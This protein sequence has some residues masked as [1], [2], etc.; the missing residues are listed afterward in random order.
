M[1][2]INTDY[3][4]QVGAMRIIAHGQKFK[5]VNN[6]HHYN[7]YIHII[8]CTTFSLW[9]PGSTTCNRRVIIIIV[10]HLKILT[11]PTKIF[12][13]Y[14]PALRRYTC[15]FQVYPAAVH[16]PSRTVIS[17]CGS[18][19]TTPLLK[20]CIY[21]IYDILSFYFVRKF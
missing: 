5:K 19:P 20:R 12:F 9:A 2:T 14:S 4:C 8:L 16:V 7:V 21:K 15:T 1:N 17:S 11:L 6:Q 18:T 10:T 13:S 3:A